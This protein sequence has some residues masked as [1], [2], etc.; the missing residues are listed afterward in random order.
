MVETNELYLRGDDGE[1]IKLDVPDG[2][3]KGV[4]REWLS[5]ELRQPWSVGGMNWFAVVPTPA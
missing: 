3:Q 1:L 2:A 4:F 5:V